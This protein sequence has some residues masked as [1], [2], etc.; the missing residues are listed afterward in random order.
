MKHP[1]GRLHEMLKSSVSALRRIVDPVRTKQMVEAIARAAPRRDGPGARFR[2]VRPEGRPYF[3]TS[4]PQVRVRDGVPTLWVLVT[5]R[6][7]YLHTTKGWRDR[8][9][10]HAWQQVKMPGAAR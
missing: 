7:R 10:G 3:V 8:A 6:Q 2:H 5:R 4:A 9:L 1:L